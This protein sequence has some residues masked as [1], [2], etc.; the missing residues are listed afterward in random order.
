[1]PISEQVAILLN[2]GFTGR[3]DAGRWAG[4]IQL[5][6]GLFMLDTVNR[7]GV[8]P[9]FQMSAC[10]GLAD[11]ARLLKA[12]LTELELSVAIPE[13]NTAPDEWVPRALE[14]LH[15]DDAY[16][17]HGGIQDLLRLRAT[18]A[19]GVELPTSVRVSVERNIEVSTAAGALV[20]CTLDGY[21]GATSPWVSQYCS[22]PTLRCQPGAS[23]DAQIAANMSP[24]EL[25]LVRSLVDATF[26]ARRRKQ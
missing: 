5:L 24:N 4:Q 9:E 7:T 23:L 8:I 14:L 12:K 3:R 10:A 22:W 16:D 18:D 6:C 19:L 1:M 2:P 21:C 15:S 13:D 11:D 26:R 20:A 17:V 25:A